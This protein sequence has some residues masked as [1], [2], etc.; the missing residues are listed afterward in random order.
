MLQGFHE[1]TD[2][3]H[4]IYATTVSRKKG[5][6]MNTLAVPFPVEQCIAM[7]SSSIAHKKI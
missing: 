5:A 4:E 1:K 3:D 2:C 7:N 6:L